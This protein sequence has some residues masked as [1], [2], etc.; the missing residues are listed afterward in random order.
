MDRPCSALDWSLERQVRYLST[1]YASG[2][3]LGT[4]HH[5]RTVLPI[6]APSSL[7]SIVVVGV[8]GL[9][10]RVGF[11]LVGSEQGRCMGFASQWPLLLQST[12]SRVHGLPELWLRGSREQVVVHRLKGSA[13]C[14]FFPDQGLN[15]CPPHWQVDS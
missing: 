5:I 2:S 1:C 4:S 8:L 15:P 7:S 11:S 6:G 14:G 12:G 13:P 9:H 3:S 10:C